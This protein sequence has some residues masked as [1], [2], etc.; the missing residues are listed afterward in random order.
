M[1]FDFHPNRKVHRLYL[2]EESKAIIVD[3]SRQLYPFSESLFSTRRTRRSFPAKE[4]SVTG[5]SS[6]LPVPTFTATIHH[7]FYLPLNIDL[8]LCISFPSSSFIL[9]P[10][11]PQYGKLY[12]PP[13]VRDRHVKSFAGH[14]SARSAEQLLI[15]LAEV[16]GSMSKMEGGEGE[17]ASGVRFSMGKRQ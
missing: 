16:Q 17:R 9:C 11:I 15:T 3:V 14:K 5:T 4:T 2:V 1:N 6:T 7:N 8:T 13:K 10:P 12:F